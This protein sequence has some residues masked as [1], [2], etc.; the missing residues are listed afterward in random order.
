MVKLSSKKKKKGSPHQ[1]TD[2]VRVD[3]HLRPKPS[4]HSWVLICFTGKVCNELARL[5]PTSPPQAQNMKNWEFMHGSITFL[6]SFMQ[7]ITLLLRCN[8]YMASSVLPGG[9]I[10]PGGPVGPGEPSDPVTGDP[11]RPRAPGIPG[12]PGSPA[13]TQPPSNQIAVG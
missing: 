13:H 10:G 6:I 1:E 8:C 9:P 3:T 11:G 5:T 7:I 4:T 12:V 2:T